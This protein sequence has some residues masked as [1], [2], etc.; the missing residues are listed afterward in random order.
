MI[1]S[2]LSRFLPTRIEKATATMTE[3]NWARY[4]LKK[5]LLY[6]SL[7]SL[8][9]MGNRKMVVGRVANTMVAPNMDIINEADE[10][11]AIPTF[12]CLP[13]T[14]SRIPYIKPKKAAKV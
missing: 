11:V 10:V 9:R 13:L 2:T 14:F 5:P 8:P 7:D 4:I 3:L 1:V 6:L 12:D